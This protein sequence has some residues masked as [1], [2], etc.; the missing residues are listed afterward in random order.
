MTTV[1]IYTYKMDRYK[2]SD[3]ER[4]VLLDCL[5]HGLSAVNESGRELD[6]DDKK[7][8]AMVYKLIVKLR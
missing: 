4:E 3:A 1:T 7:W 6:T 2:L 8:R 5:D